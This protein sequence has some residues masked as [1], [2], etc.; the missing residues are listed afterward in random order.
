MAAF[1]LTA[2]IQLQ[3]PNTKRV[4]SQIQRDLSGINL[5]LNVGKSAKN[6][7][8][9]QQNLGGVAKQG[10]R[11]SKSFN[12]LSRNVA[13]AARRFSVITV[14]TGS[15]I[16][17]ARGI[18]SS[19][20]SAIE[21]QRELV[22]ISQVTGKNLDQ[23][24]GLQNE[25]TRLST[26][27]GVANADLLQTSRVLA[28]AGLSALKTRQALEVLAQTTLAPTFDTI[29]D[30]TEGAIAIL[31]Q[32]GRE[33]A[34]TGND[35]KFLENSLDAIN[36]VSKNFAVES[37]DLI[38]TVRRTGGVFEAA[39]GNLKELI[40]LFTSVRQTTREGA[41]TI[42]TG[43]RT[44][45]TRLQRKDTIEALNELGIS[46]QDAEGKFI[47][48]LKAIEKLSIGLAGLDPKDVRFNEIV[49]QL[50][51]F[52]QIGKVIP[53]IKQFQVTQQALAVANNSVGS[54]SKDAQ[55]AQKSLA[56]QLGKTRE[57]F[58]ALIRKF[59]DSSTFQDS[60]KFVL[61]L[62]DTFLKFA[63]SLETVLPLLT[64]FAAIKLGRS[65]APGLSQLFG[66]GS[67]RRNAGGKILGFNRGGLVPGQGNGDTVPAMLEPGE[68]VIRKSSVKKL[69]S[70][71]L[72]QMNNN[73]YETGGAVEL[74]RKSATVQDLIY[75]GKKNISKKSGDNFNLSK[76]Q[77][78]ENDTFSSDIKRTKIKLRKS[79]VDRLPKLDK[80]ELLNSSNAI[81]QGNAFEK[82]LLTSGRM[83][84]PAG[85]G[86]N[87]P[88]DGK[89]GKEL[90]EVK[91]TAVS[92]ATLLDKNLR[93]Q[94]E[95]GNKLNRTRLSG[96]SDRIGLPPLT[97]LSLD[98]SSVSTL[99]D[100]KVKP[101]REALGGLIQKFALGGIAQKNKIG[102]AILDPDMGKSPESVSVGVKDVSPYI[103]K[104]TE[105]QAKGIS[106]EYSS[107]KY[108]IVRQGLNQKTSDGFKNTLLDGAAK[109]V[110]DAV[111]G[112]GEDLGLGSVKPD[113]SDI[114]NLK[115]KIRSSGAL[116]GP[117][118]NALNLLSN[119]GRFKPS[120]VNAPFDFPDGLSGAVKDNY[121]NLPGSYI[122]AKSSYSAAETSGMKG[123]IA[124]EIA[125]EYKGS[126]TYKSLAADTGSGDKAGIQKALR[127]RFP[128]RSD[129]AGYSLSD[130]QTATGRKYKASELK[131]LGFTKS[132]GTNYL[133]SGGSAKGPAPSDTVP[134]LLTP[135]EFVFRKEAAQSIGYDKLGKM[136]KKGVKGFAK[137]GAVGVQKF[138]AGGGP[139]KSGDFGLAK[140][141][142]LA[143]VN[144]QAKA[145]AAAFK[146]L[147]EKI[148]S[149]NLGTDGAKAA[150]LNFA[151]NFDS[152]ADTATQVQAAL[153]K[154]KNIDDGFKEVGSSRSGK[155]QSG[156]GGNSEGRGS[157]VP[158][159]G[160]EVAKITQEADAL[161]EQ[162][163]V[164]GEETRA[165]QKAALAY[166]K[167]ITNGE[168]RQDALNKGIKAGQDATNALNKQMKDLTDAYA[169]G[170]IS[171]EQLSESSLKLSKER[172]AKV[173]PGRPGGPGPDGPGPDGPGPDGSSFSADEL[174]SEADALSESLGGISNRLNQVST[175]AI[176]LTLVGGTLIESW[177]GLDDVTKKQYQ[178]VLNSISASVALYAQ[179]GSLGLEFASTIAVSRLRKQADTQVAAAA[180]KAAAALN[181]IQPGGGGGG[182]GAGKGTKV[183]AGI[184]GA[185]AGVAILKIVIDAYAAAFVAGQ[186]A[187][188]E[189]ANKAADKELER[190]SSGTGGS[191]ERFVAQ[192]RKAAEADLRIQTRNRDDS[193]RTKAGVYTGL[194]A[195]LVAGIAAAALAVNVIPGVGQ[196]ASAALV[197]L[198]VAVVAGAAAVEVYNAI[199]ATSSA[200][201]EENL[202]LAGNAAE[203]YARTQFRA[204]KS[205]Q[206]L[207]VALKEAADAGVNTSQQIQVL[208][209]ATDSSASEY[210]AG[211]QRL[212]KARAEE[213]KLRQNLIE[214]GVLTAGG[215]VS[216][217]AAGDDDSQDQ[218]KNLDELTKGREAAE[219]SQIDLIRKTTAESATFRTLAQKA[220]SE[221]LKDISKLGPAALANVSSFN[222]LAAQTPG[223]AEAFNK[224]K[225]KIQLLDRL[226][227]NEELRGEEDPA[228][229]QALIAKAAA[230]TVQSLAQLDT[231][232]QQL[233]LSEQKLA[234]SALLADQ[235]Q[236]QQALTL[237]R[238]N[239]NL[240][241]FNLLLLQSS[242]LKEVFGAIDDAGATEFGAVEFD[243]SI[244]DVTFKQL[245]DKAIE[246]INQLGSGTIGKD[247][248]GFAKNIRDV[249]SI[250]KSLPSVFLDFQRDTDG[251]IIDLPKLK[252]QLTEQIASSVPGGLDGLGGD[253]RAIIEKNADEAISSKGGLTGGLSFEDQKKLQD[254][255]EASIEAQIAVFKRAVELQ[256]QFLGKLSQINTKIVA[257]QEG[258]INAQAKFS[259]VFERN[260][261][262]LANANEKPRSRQETEEGRT[263]TAN[264]NLG[265][266]ARNAGAR[267][268]D[269][270]STAKAFK[271]LNKEA[272]RLRREQRE[273]A[274][275][276]KGNIDINSQT[277]IE[278][279]KLQKG[280]N[281]AAKGAARARAEL[282]RL[283]DQ[284]ARAADVEKDLTKL[285][286]KR[287][288]AESLQESIAFGSDNQRQE[289]FKGF[290][291]LQQAFNQGGIQGATGDQRAAIGGALDSIGS[292]LINFEG[293]QV[294]GKELKQIFAARETGRLGLGGLNNFIDNLRKAENPLLGELK[295][296]AQTELVASA[297]LAGI[298]VNELKTL[299]SI[300]STLKTAFQQ[301]LS[302]AKA[303]AQ[304][305]FG[306][307]EGAQQGTIDSNAETLLG[308][309]ARISEQTTAVAKQTKLMT[310][311]SENTLTAIK[312]LDTAQSKKRER[313]ES[314]TTATTR[315]RGGPAYFNNGGVVP[316][317]APTPKGMEKVF[318]PKGTDTVPAM[319]QKG[320]FVIKKSSVDKIG[321]DALQQ[322]NN[323][324]TVYAA[325]GFNAGLSF[326]SGKKS[327][328]DL[329][330]VGAAEKI[331]SQNP[332]SSFDASKL[333]GIEK[334][335]VSTGELSASG[336]NERKVA[337][338]QEFF[339]DVGGFLSGES[340][341]DFAKRRADL[342]RQTGYAVARDS[343][344]R[345]EQKKNSKFNVIQKAVTRENVLA[346]LPV[347]GQILGAADVVTTAGKNVLTGG[348]YD[349]ELVGSGA[350]FGGSLVNIPGLKFAG[351][352]AGKL[353]N[354]G[355]GKKVGNAVKQKGLDAALA[356][357]LT[358]TGRTTIGAGQ[359]ALQSRTGQL[360]AKFVSSKAQKD[361]NLSAPFTGAAATETEEALKRAKGGA[362]YRREG[363]NDKE[364]KK[365][366]FE[367]YRNTIGPISAIRKE[368]GRPIYKSQRDAFGQTEKDNE[369]TLDEAKFFNVARTPEEVEKFE[370]R[371]FLAGFTGDSK[372]SN[373]NEAA[374]DVEF[375][376]LKNNYYSRQLSDKEKSSI[377]FK[378]GGSIYYE[379]KARD[380]YF[381]PQQ[382]A[383]GDGY[384]R[385][386]AWVKSGTKPAQ[387]QT[388][389]QA[390]TEESP[391][392][393]TSEK[394]NDIKLAGD[395]RGGDISVGIAAKN[396]SYKVV[397]INEARGQ[398]GI[399]G[400][401]EAAAQGATLGQASDDAY[402]LEENRKKKELQDIQNENDKRQKPNFSAFY[403]DIDN[404]IALAQEEYREF[405]KFTQDPVLTK[406]EAIGDYVQKSAKNKLGRPFAKSLAAYKTAVK[407]GE[408]KDD[409]A[410]ES[411]FT[412]YGK[413]QPFRSNFSAQEP[414]QFALSANEILRLR[415]EAK[416]KKE[417]ADK[418]AAK[419]EQDNADLKGYQAYKEQINQG[420]DF[421]LI[422][423]ETQANIDKN[424]NKFEKKYQNELAEEKARK[425]KAAAD[426]KAE[427][428]KKAGG[429]RL[430]EAVVKAEDKAKQAKKEADVRKKEQ[431]RAKAE[432]EAENSP[433]AKQA[434]R[435]KIAA[436][437]RSAA[438]DA[439]IKSKEAMEANAQRLKDKQDRE[440]AE[441]EQRDTIRK[442][443]REAYVNAF[444]DKLDEGTP[445]YAQAEKQAEQEWLKDKKEE[446]RKSR[447]ASRAKAQAR[448]G[449]EGPNLNTAAGRKKARLSGVKTDIEAK[450]QAEQ[451]KNLEQNKDFDPD[452][453]AK[454]QKYNSILRRNGPRAASKY[455]KTVGLKSNQQANP[456][457]A[458]QQQNGNQ[459]I[460]KFLLNLLK[461]GGVDTSQ[462]IKG[463]NNGG[464]TV[465]NIPAMLTSGEFVMNA[466]ASKQ[467]GMSNL[468][469]MN[470][471]GVMPQK[472][473]KGGV[474]GG[475]KTSYLKDGGS[476]S[477]GMGPL[478]INVGP[479]SEVLNKFSAAFGNKLDNVVGQFDYVAGAM[480]N[481]AQSI[482]QGMKVTHSFNG[483]MKM[484]FSMSD[485]QTTNIVN[486]VGDAMTPKME[487]IIKR[488]VD[489]K[490]NKNSFKSGG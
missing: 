37:S 206:A 390:Q 422:P 96:G 461:Q 140:P 97:E 328:F 392:T 324:G 303:D 186:K 176:G 126:S 83:K 89:K 227:L 214:D 167:A 437:A 251:K 59:T 183:A 409:T 484:T 63:E 398:R 16:A 200:R 473:A 5:N 316:G 109:G 203:G 309:T 66:R 101:K 277:S 431:D 157:L 287:S 273:L 374:G 139:V 55:E 50:G 449:S 350:R 344:I 149:L 196:V 188:Q 180:A 205:A 160:D 11:A 443:E 129:R 64:Q 276:T 28:Q 334:A 466:K 296:I 490:F 291:L 275:S 391:R 306:G 209:S 365:F 250:T 457:N 116:G 233:I 446:A 318:K 371:E 396:D 262:R 259:E 245:N 52:R 486:A 270:N 377:G 282:E 444:T 252:K 195:G 72:H 98:K 128:K 424:R 436:D 333:T 100:T 401:K 142:D 293:Q 8:A 90:I 23:L 232:S 136:N 286:E 26:S 373:I 29:I 264:L 56:V 480:D 231:E 360:G 67:Q 159:S 415:G 474:V 35:I 308:L 191:E 465:D 132:G 255:L 41:E 118:E 284:S 1:N 9:V 321:K 483:D 226:K 434:R 22:K 358:K 456:Q 78:T 158:I 25:V 430:G 58:D 406:K 76:N 447:D 86:D 405:R 33:A 265:A 479:F 138:A 355:V 60:A 179:F 338:F 387:T 477:G 314:S 439:R 216:A 119:K 65:L 336:A 419:K 153:D 54:T 21:F 141:K 348:D 170:E 290:R 423:A 289:I 242:K 376:R 258:I 356:A 429:G 42:A 120:P 224:A 488:E 73:R 239:K 150:V 172:K 454:V 99:A 127:S 331:T 244:F 4:A 121:D 144:A 27:L 369:F 213:A 93:H 400:A 133:N 347:S 236:R 24:K 425:T 368:Q 402:A 320:E 178:A 408:I 382:S 94:L 225:E 47:G 432:Y 164:L 414:P 30:T 154:A 80:A 19:I 69:G 394:T 166:R 17:L 79:V 397:D 253:I 278:V 254:E 325:N 274:Q 70:G 163:N 312:N 281:D 131:E 450:N 411:D 413:D 288:E 487:E 36:A 15:F 440:K 235:A 448:A 53:L 407:K 39:G 380:T 12:L 393:P 87:K 81:A 193:G 43:F 105:A 279:G 341:E 7:A 295:D 330:G 399:I 130:F 207:T 332:R 103:T 412:R 319:L 77:F 68:F 135:G 174:T 481:L 386:A 204:T 346:D 472:F 32:F 476:P 343:A 84:A 366:D 442:K 240:S 285:R 383:S 107:K 249:K 189:A 268:G 211:T 110:N 210:A 260:A 257:A 155:K 184:G 222:D 313:Q 197:G 267:A 272:A 134:A 145:N 10:D 192:R 219:K 40:A 307:S 482:S 323:G 361:A 217:A 375:E 171:E 223:L 124:Q 357:G 31:N 304:Q 403:S 6:L 301:E 61:K 82:Y 143:L 388:E 18:K 352:G 317:S 435:D 370:E 302:N 445:A 146:Q 108:S 378:P 246:R 359:N 364:K 263:R 169:A 173:L 215:N 104:S 345:G 322:M 168:T 218:I 395:G 182:G 229:R 2:E 299:K 237:S 311:L 310:R 315:S 48:P 478:E 381:K 212:E 353:L 75:R 45:F 156:V 51:G 410:L 261:D 471:K 458:Q 115:E 294:T 71:Q 113:P 362:V 464:G 468:K 85:F 297:A 271:D 470:E 199:F 148:N 247:A 20:G 243:T 175:A 151:R 256:N 427:R 428:V 453:A 187:I 241:A 463:F 266:T 340:G 337:G 441:K 283:A 372:S 485:E 389:A 418:K 280:A 238:V 433:Q 162:F 230:Q 234:K 248:D 102:A 460:I 198:A 354:T 292:Q 475:M 185:L 92:P 117:F 125:A 416:S 300:D 95:T 452:R 177:T 228:V 363:S 367:K 469:D 201:L 327:K 13:E 305:E 46:L 57:S 106:K 421:S 379:Q 111:S 417:A 3:A 190:V 404:E 335:K 326:G 202:S 459:Q 194:G 438:E 91:R 451:E 44:I 14:A 349:A 122:D 112:L 385:G 384:A 342:Q 426:R 114:G 455:A 161:S 462:L 74:S 123:K 165:G 152:A 351:K 137:G 147:T 467:I 298:A 34:K 88:L 329:S 420:G 38:A 221:G 220:V 489:Q 269:V 49:E 62:A 181:G 339:S 208:A